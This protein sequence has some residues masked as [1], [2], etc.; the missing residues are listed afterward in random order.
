MGIYNRKGTGKK[1]KVISDIGSEINCS[2][3]AA[4]K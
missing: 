4:I 1:R 3:S 2:N